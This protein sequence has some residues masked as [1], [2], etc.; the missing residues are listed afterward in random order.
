MCRYVCMSMCMCQDMHIRMHAYAQT[1]THMHAHVQGEKDYVTPDNTGMGALASAMADYI[2][3]YKAGKGGRV[4]KY[5]TGI[6]N[7]P[8]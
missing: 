2:G 5:L 1:H 4:E 3:A 7:D 8:R 6:L